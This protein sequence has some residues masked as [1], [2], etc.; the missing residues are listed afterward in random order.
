MNIK[1]YDTSFGLDKEKCIKQLDMC[2]EL[3]FTKFK[4]R[5]EFFQN[6]ID[7]NISFSRRNTKSVIN[8][9]TESVNVGFFKMFSNPASDEGNHVKYSNTFH[10]NM[11]VFVETADPTVERVRKLN[12]HRSKIL[13]LFVMPNKKRYEYSF[14]GIF[15]YSHTEGNSDYFNRIS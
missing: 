3:A 15:E 4:N 12:R 8:L 1:L 14:A 10:N 9:G 6:Y 11:N 5:N 13:Y 7:E 2:P